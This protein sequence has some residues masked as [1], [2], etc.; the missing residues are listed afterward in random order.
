MRPFAR[1]V[2]LSC[3]IFQSGR[4]QSPFSQDSAAAYLRV[5]SVVIGP[6]TMGSPAERTAM[7]Y[8]VQKFE[9]FG[10]RDVS[11]MEMSTSADETGHPVNTRSG[12][13]VAVLPGRSER[14][15]VLGGH[16]DTA[17]PEVPGTNDDG[18][19]AATVIELARVLSKRPNNSTIVF[20]LFGG[21][22]QGLRGSEYFVDHYAALDK[23]A[24]MIQLD[25]ANGSEWLIPMVDVHSHSAPEWLVRAAYEE[26][27]KLGYKGL[28]FPTHFSTLDVAFGSGGAGSDHESFLNKD[29]PAIDFT[30]DVSDPIHTPRDNFENFDP[31]GLKRSG[32]LTYKLVE[33]FDDGVPPE[34][35]GAYYLVQPGTFPLMIPSVFVEIILLA[36]VIFGWTAVSLAR[37]RRIE[38]AFDAR[39]VVPGLKLFLLSLIIQLCVWIAPPLVG[40]IKGD[41]FGWFQDGSGYF[42]LGFFASLIG[43]WLSL[44]LSRRLKLSRDPYR[45]L[46]RAVFSFTFLV[47]LFRFTGTRNLALYPALGLMFAAAASLVPNP[48]AKILLWLISPYWM[49][50]LFFSEAFSLFSRSLVASIPDGTTNFLFSVFLI[51]FFSLWSYPF[52]LT[53]AS[54]ALD[55]PAIAWAISVF[56]RRSGIAAAGTLFVGCVAW[57]ALQPTFSGRWNRIVRVEQQVDG[58]TGKGTATVRSSHYLGGVRIRGLGIDTM[59]QG[60]IL[61]FPLGSTAISGEPWVMVDRT[62]APVTS[63]SGVAVDITL[64][65]HMKYRPYTLHVGYSAPGSIISDVASPLTISASDH[66]VSLDWYSFPD[67][68]LYIPLHFALSRSD[69]VIESI[70]ATFARDAEPV[71]VI[72]PFTTALPR[73]VVEFSTPLGLH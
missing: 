73:T 47:L 68:S 17:G 64:L 39:P 45:F 11:I 20:C 70:E 22:E 41:R 56:R 72:A 46:F 15:I 71:S 7:E 31:R 2:F 53:F 34:K 23:V 35:R 30:S 3:L 61:E 48:A 66:V 44:Q 43:I 8:G 14:A 19:G 59:A 32:D 26:F 27:D 18:S 5:I 55:A 51:L 69:S 62:I 54:I 37:R 12:A 28:S 60:R 58:V 16:I 6:R 4:A 21:E 33:R 57:L 67:T 1:L 13:V 63:D 40:F 50:R 29:I 24:L 10:I 65:L 36:S 38:V 25:M 49:F 42:L 52:L 9:E